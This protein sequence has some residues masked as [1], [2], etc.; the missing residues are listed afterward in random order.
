MNISSESLTNNE[1]IALGVIEITSIPHISIIN[2]KENAATEIVERYK[3]EMGSMLGEVYQ[4]YK[5]MRYA[6]GYSKD[7]SLELLW[8]TQ[9]VQNQPYNAQ[10]R[11]F[12]V[13]RAIDND[14]NSATQSVASLIKLCQSTLSLQKYE[15]QEIDYS[16]FAECVLRINDTKIKAVVKEEKAENLQNQILPFCYSYDRI[17]ISNND[18]SRIVNVLIDYPDCAVSMQLIPTSLEMNETAE[19]D[20]ITQ[21]LDTLS[22]GVADQGIGNISFALAEKHANVY[23]YYSENKTSALFSFNVLIYGD[24]TAISNISSRV[25]SQLSSGANATADLRLIDLDK[26]EVGKDNN[27]YPLPWAV[28]E[29]LVGKERNNSIWASRQFSNALYRLPYVITAEEA[30]E[31]FRLPIGSDRITAGLKINESGKGNKTYSANIINAG[32]ITIGKLRSS[33]KGDTIGFSLKDL[34]VSGNDLISLGIPKGKKIGEILKKLLDLVIDGEIP[35]DKDILLSYAV[36][37]YKKI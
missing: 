18:L 13:V 7:I 12:V 9:A 34:A 15:I 29:I 32:D 33:T 19:I 2:D 10:I 11:L 35:N 26:T 37:E 30:S 20:R 22:K 4:V 3:N 23:R 8:I 17:P 36:K 16:V 1:K 28:N 31:F 5:S 14:A 25:F 21:A 27:F 6:N 24:S